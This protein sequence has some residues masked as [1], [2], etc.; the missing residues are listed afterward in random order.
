[1]EE[2]SRNTSRS[3]Y[4]SIFQ[5]IGWISYFLL[6]AGLLIL[7]RTISSLSILELL[8]NASLCVIGFFLTHGFR[9]LLK[10]YRW[11]FL[12]VPR[13]IVLVLVLNLLMAVISTAAIQQISRWV[14]F[15]L[16]SG[17]LALLLVNNFS[18][19][20]FWS[21]IYFGISI[22][23]RYRKEEIER[24][25]WEG[26]L[27]EFE[28]KKLKSQLNPHF[29]FN[30]LNGIR[31]L[32]GEDPEKAKLAI[33]QLSS[34]LRNSLLSDRAQT[35]SISE[36]IKTVLEYL[37]L[38]K[39]RFDERL[40]FEVTIDENCMDRE[41]PPMMIQTLVEN[42]VKHGISRMVK[43][44]KIIVQGEFSSDKLHI[45][46]A[47]SGNLGSEKSGGFGIP[48]TRQRLELVYGKEASFNIFQA[49]PDMVMAQ[50]IIPVKNK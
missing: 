21:G 20:V 32:V 29:V 13:L 2:V 40:E 33:T 47:N 4:Y 3:D 25:R 44:G 8:P 37:N 48:N 27:K 19:F 5:F 23:R 24:L 50:L 12:P 11:N 31:S 36:E 49:S 10:K 17:D 30:A 35:I 16:V 6:M 1:M 42:A 38:E 9:Y 18:L 22:F 46:I 26:A 28:L 43:G 39:I 41:V 45:S 15:A 34:I 7:N 14:T